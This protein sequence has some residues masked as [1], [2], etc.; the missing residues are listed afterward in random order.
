MRDP[1]RP[2]A[3]PAPWASVGVLTNDIASGGIVY[4]E[5][6]LNALEKGMEL[7]RLVRGGLHEVRCPTLLIYGDADQIVDKANAP[8]S[9]ASPDTPLGHMQR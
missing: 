1:N 9:I 6:P 4:M 7:I 8:P 3:I 2:K 5:M